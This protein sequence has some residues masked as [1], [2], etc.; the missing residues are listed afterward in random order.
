M[1][2]RRSQWLWALTLWFAIL[3]AGATW[4]AQA[5][6]SERV[7]LYA[8][9][10]SLSPAAL[11]LYV[12]VF[13]LSGVGALVAATGL[14]FRQDWARYAALVS[15]ATYLSASQTY[16]WIYVQAG[17]SWERRWVTLAGALLAVTFSI[18]ALT[19]RRSTTRLGLG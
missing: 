7:L 6:W 2:R 17:L 12:A 19:W 11:T 5:L 4:R 9:G 8:L 13:V 16:T 14:W 1:K 3:G 15:V 18:V 10:S